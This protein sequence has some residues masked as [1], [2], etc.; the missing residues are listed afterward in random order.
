MPDTFS[1]RERQI[2]DILF[3]RGRAT[4]QEVREALA[5][6]PT[7]SAVRGLLRVMEGK[8][9]VRHVREG[10]RY[11]YMPTQARAG[12]ARTALR[13]V[14]HTFFGGSVSRVVA[15]LLS[16]AYGQLSDA[17]LS[18][19]SAL[20]AASAKADDRAGEAGDD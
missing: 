9:H 11:V 20:I 4:A 10:A 5:D 2:M 13:Q 3:A 16:E 1:R 8:G 6:P 17:E 15:T 19:L 18:R 12:A 7:Y 14:L